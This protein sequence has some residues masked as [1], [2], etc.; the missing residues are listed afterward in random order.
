V[1]HPWLKNSLCFSRGNKP[2]QPASVVIQAL[3]VND[4]AH[5]A[6]ENQGRKHDA[7]N[8]LGP[9]AA[10]P[11]LLAGK[12]HFAQYIK[13][14]KIFSGILDENTNRANARSCSNSSLLLTRDHFRKPHSTPLF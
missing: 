8:H 6:G 10:F 9:A 7:D 14:H 5:A 11:A 2:L 12:Q 4:H 13:R 1:F 3:P